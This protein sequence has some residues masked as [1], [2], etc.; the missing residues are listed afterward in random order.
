MSANWMRM[1]F[2]PRS[3]SWPSERLG[4]L[5]PNWRI[6]TLDAVYAITNGGVVPGGICL[7]IA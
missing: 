2:V 6:G 3:N 5:S 4:L 1:K 7:S